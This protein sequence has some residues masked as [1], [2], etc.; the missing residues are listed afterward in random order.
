VA[1]QVISVCQ[2]TIVQNAWRRGRQLT[3]H[4]L[5]YNIEDGLLLD[6]GI[7]IDG[8]EQI[9]PIYRMMAPDSTEGIRAV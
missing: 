1:Q 3:V 5:I 2:T 9:A 6:M 7:R 4:G 8:P